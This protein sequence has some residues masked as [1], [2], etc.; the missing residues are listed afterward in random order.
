MVVNLWYSNCPPCA[1]ELTYFAAVEAD[2]GDDIRFVGVNPL[3][4]VDE[5]RRFAAERGVDYE[6][7]MRSRRLRSTMRSASCSIP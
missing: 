5:M 6:L 3:D 4:D 7:L 1:R 2:V